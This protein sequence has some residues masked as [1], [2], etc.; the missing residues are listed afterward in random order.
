VNIHTQTHTH[1]PTRRYLQR[2]SASK[3]SHYIDADCHTRRMPPT[4]YCIVFHLRRRSKLRLANISRTAGSRPLG[5]RSAYRTDAASAIPHATF[6]CRLTTSS[7]SSPLAVGQHAVFFHL[8]LSVV[9]FPSSP[10]AAIICN[11]AIRVVERAAS[12]RTLFGGLPGN[13]R[14]RPRF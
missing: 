14:C 6:H 12:A 3:L 9:V 4:S 13:K 5:A 10:H 11:F 2:L 1:T 7:S 8:F